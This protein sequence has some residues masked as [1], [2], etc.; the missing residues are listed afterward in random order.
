MGIK[1]SKQCHRCS[2]Q[3]LE[4]VGQQEKSYNKMWQVLK[5]WYNINNS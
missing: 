5:G 1:Q 4:K 2:L 3:G